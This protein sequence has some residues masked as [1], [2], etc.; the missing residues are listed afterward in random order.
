MNDAVVMVRSNLENIPN[1][2]LPAGYTLRWY[3]PGDE[4][5][6][7]EI[8]SPAYAAN[9]ITPA[10]FRSEFG[11]DEA[12]LSRRQCYLLNGD[13]V[14]IATN[15]AWFNDDYKGQPYGRVHWVAISPAWQ[16]MGLAK[17][18]MS[19]VCERLHAL[20]HARAYLTTSTTRVRALNLYLQFGFVPEINHGEELEAWRAVQNQLKYPVRLE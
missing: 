12:E 6:W 11:Q 18:L 9:A 14:P 5:R 3:Q 7:V 10:L 8:Q 17:P 1:F 4:D 13:G 16:G 20:G 15:T 2:S 19:R